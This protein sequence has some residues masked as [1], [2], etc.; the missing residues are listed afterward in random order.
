MRDF[1]SECGTWGIMEGDCMERMKEIPDGVVAT[2]IVDPPYGMSFQSNRRG[3]DTKHRKIAGD[4]T[5]EWLLPAYIHTKRIMTKNSC[6][7][8]FCSMHRIGWFQET[9]G[10]LFKIKNLLTWVKNNTGMGDLHGAWAPK[11]EFCFHAQK[12]RVLLNGGR[13][14]DIM[15]FSRTQNK[16]HPTQKPVDMLQYLIEKTSNP[17]D[18]VLDFTMG[19]GSTGVAAIQCGRKFIGIEK[20]PKYYEVALKRLQKA[21]NEKTLSGQTEGSPERAVEAEK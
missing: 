12:G 19:S 9:I 2:V 1:F 8:S 4:D 20:D 16:L 21:W 14:P 17:G 11:T 13:D 6:L 10:G 7:L 3:V 5:V 15:E 18:I